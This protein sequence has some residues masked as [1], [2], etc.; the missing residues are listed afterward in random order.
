MRQKLADFVQHLS[1]AVIGQECDCGH[2]PFNP[3]ARFMDRH[4]NTDDQWDM[5]TVTP[6]G[7]K[8]L[9]ACRV[10]DRLRVIARRLDQ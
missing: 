5:E 10:S 9:L 2:N 3:L 4:V 1:W 7:R 8:S 6:I